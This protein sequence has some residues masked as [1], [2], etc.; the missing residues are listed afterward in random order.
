MKGAVTVPCLKYGNTTEIRQEED[1]QHN[2]DILLELSVE[3]HR[4][5]SHFLRKMSLFHSKLWEQSHF[6]LMTESQQG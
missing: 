1:K 5:Q 4:T 6:S 2:V 3:R